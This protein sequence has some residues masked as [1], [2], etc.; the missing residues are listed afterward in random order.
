M[1]KIL[2]IF[3]LCL[4]ATALAQADSVS[5]LSSVY[6]EKAPVLYREINNPVKI[7]VNNAKS[8]TATAFGL[9][10]IDDN[11]NYE[12]NVTSVS[13][14]LATIDI[15]IILNNGEHKKEQHSFEIRLMDFPFIKIGN[16]KF[17]TGTTVVLSKK[18]L[19]NKFEFD[20][21]IIQTNKT[22]IT[23]LEI[24]LANKKVEVIK[25]DILTPEVI[26]KINSFKN[27]SRIRIDIKYYFK[28]MENYTVKDIYFYLVNIK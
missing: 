2:T 25:G 6:I 28:G 5:Q 13:G 3:F 14:T 16:T 17:T 7:I 12:Y 20:Y 8:F 18:D 19:N 10:K 15:D 11:G 4:S 1:K 9:K 21:P 27:G 26:R 23:G 24:E 22:S